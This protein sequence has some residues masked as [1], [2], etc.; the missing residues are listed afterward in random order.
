[1]LTDQTAFSASTSP[2][3]DLRVPS[4]TGM[5][6]G[7]KVV[8]I[9]RTTT[10]QPSEAA[11]PSGVDVVLAICDLPG[12]DHLLVTHLTSRRRSHPLW[13]VST[14]LSL[15]RTPGNLGHAPYPLERRHHRHDTESSPGCISTFWPLFS[16]RLD[17]KVEVRFRDTLGPPRHGGCGTDAGRLWGRNF[18]ERPSRVL[19]NAPRHFQPWIT[20]TGVKVPA[21]VSLVPG[22]PITG[23]R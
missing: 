16:R 12:L 5:A 1:M 3:G 23:P 9:A 4:T 20:P 22:S 13:P 7:G 2:I 18:D 19:W 15:T 11:G 21:I 17:R 10:Q 6:L 14:L 8:D